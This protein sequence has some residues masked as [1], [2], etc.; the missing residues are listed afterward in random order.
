[1]TDTPHVWTGEE[2]LALPMDPEHHSAPCHVDTVRGYLAA[3]LAELWCDGEGFSGKRPFGDSGWESELYY[4]LIRAGVVAGSLD[5]DGYLDE[6]DSH[7]AD[8]K[9]A[10]AIEALGGAA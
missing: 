2:I 4:P 5:P 7:T 1:M 8:E 3:L 6:V 10:L 9:I